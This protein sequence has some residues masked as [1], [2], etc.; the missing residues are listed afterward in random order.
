MGC[1][2]EAVPKIADVVL[3][4]ESVGHRV[5]VFLVPCDRGIRDVNEAKQPAGAAIDNGSELTVAPVWG[6][7]T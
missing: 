2:R 6:F 5:T 3:G 1:G 7:P 4:M